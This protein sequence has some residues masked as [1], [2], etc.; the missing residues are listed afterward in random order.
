MATATRSGRANILHGVPWDVYQALRADESNDRLRMTYHDGTLILMSPLFPHD[1]AAERIGM[2]IRG[3]VAVYGI[4]IAGARS[5]TLSRRGPGVKKGVGKEPDNSYYIA[6]EA[7]IRDNSAINLEVDP[8]PDLAIEVDN[9]SDSRRKLPIY[10]RLGVPEVWRY[11][12][13][14]GTLWF[15]RLQDDGTYAGLDRSRAL[16]MLTPEI[17]LDLLALGRGIDET[18]WDQRVR[19]YARDVLV[20]RHREGEQPQA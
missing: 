1:R 20:T 5:T 14:P 18:S 8:P 17:V 19:E 12:V 10:A 6:N 15:G 16:P 3:V 11:Q 9:T 2:I 7:R 4:P 13:G